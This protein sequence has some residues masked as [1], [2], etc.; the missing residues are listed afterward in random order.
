MDKVEEL[1]RWRGNIPNT[2]DGSY[3]RQWDKAIR[4]ESMRA[5]VNIKC[6]DCMCWQAAEVKRCEIVTCPLWRYRPYQSKE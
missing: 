2:H 1:R 3:R 5:A 4:K 6:L